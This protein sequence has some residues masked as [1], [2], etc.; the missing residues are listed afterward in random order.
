[1]IVVFILLWKDMVNFYFDKMAEGGSEDLYNFR[2]MKRARI[3][4]EVIE[5]F[6]RRERGQRSLSPSPMVQRGR[7]GAP[8]VIRGIM[9]GCP[10]VVN[11]LN[12]RGRPRGRG[13]PSYSP[14]HPGG[15]GRVRAL[16]LPPQAPFLQQEFPGLRIC[17][18]AP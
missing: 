12:L 3:M 15:R 16:P 13:F 6:R 9:E 18:Q 4:I 1:M 5:D 8:G 17:K 14:P 10:G 7:A 11:T 2:G